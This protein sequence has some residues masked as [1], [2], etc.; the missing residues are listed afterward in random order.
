MWTAWNEN[1]SVKRLPP[2]ARVPYFKKKKKYCLFK[3]VQNLKGQ[4]QD[5]PLNV[6]ESTVGAGDEIMVLAAGA[7]ILLA[8]SDPIT[9]YISQGPS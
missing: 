1:C 6:N 7:A 9:C 8:A 5:N 4:K 2:E 3:I